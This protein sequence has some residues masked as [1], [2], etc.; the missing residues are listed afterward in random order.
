MVETQTWQSPNE[1]VI[2]SYCQEQ[3]TRANKFILIITHIPNA[4]LCKCMTY[5]TY[6]PASMDG[7]VNAC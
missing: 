4:Y 3:L 5:V 1:H 7:H 2:A 6:L